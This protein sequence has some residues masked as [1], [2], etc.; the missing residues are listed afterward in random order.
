MSG[1]APRKIISGA[2]SLGTTSDAFA[3][4]A[5]PNLGVQ[6]V[7]SAGVSAGV[8]TVETSP[9]FDF[10]GTWFNVGTV[11]VS[12]A[13]TVFNLDLAAKAYGF[14]RARITTV[15]VGGTIDCFLTGSG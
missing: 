3:V 14:V 7:S 11:T 9:V 12:A 13:S 6:V 15:V 1:Y 8:I 5:F 2:L 10:A 4:D